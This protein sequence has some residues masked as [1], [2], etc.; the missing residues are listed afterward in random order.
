MPDSTQSGWGGRMLGTP[1]RCSLAGACVA[2]VLAPLSLLLL[3]AVVIDGI[4]SFLPIGWAYQWIAELF[5][6]WGLPFFLLIWKLTEAVLQERFSDGVRDTL[7]RS[8][9]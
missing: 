6:L 5:F 4:P 8:V 3:S 2:L 1:G 7:D 9:P